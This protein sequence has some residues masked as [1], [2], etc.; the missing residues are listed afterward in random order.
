M[1]LNPKTLIM[2]VQKVMSA[3]MVSAIALSVFSCNPDND[4]IPVNPVSKDAPINSLYQ[5]LKQQAQSFHVNAGSQQTIT[6]ANGTVITFSPQSFKTQGGAV[7][8]S[9]SIN[10]QLTE[11][12]TPGQ[13]IMNRVSTV[14]DAGNMLQS[15]GS[16]NIIATQNGNP[17]YANIYKISFK[18]S[19]ASAQPMALFSGIVNAGGTNDGAVTWSNNSTNTVN[20]TNIL[21]GNDSMGAS[22]YIFD[23]CTNFNWIN[24]D[25]FYNAPDPKT[26]ITV[27]MPDGTYNDSTTDVL[28]ILP[29]LNLVSGM[30][31]Y[32]A[33]THSFNMGTPNY[34]VPVGTNVKVV[35]MGVKNNVYFFELKNNITVTNGMI[36]TTTP[37]NTTLS[38]IQTILS[39]L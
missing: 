32:D 28:L 19:T 30:G 8:T 33:A 11:A 34:F 31:H 21:N 36:L 26:D 17:V 27:V 16:V 6:G 25:Y 7:I 14:T 2:R 9:G 15:G 20:G 39:G 1:F 23:S 13:M 29:L 18:Q 22:Y 24:C 5:A 4:P 3:L 38:N 12:L 37:A 10:I 35:I